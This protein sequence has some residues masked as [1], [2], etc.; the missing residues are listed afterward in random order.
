LH[1]LSSFQRTGS[2]GGTS[3]PSNRVFAVIRRT[4]PEYRTTVSL[5]T[6]FFGVA[7]AYIRRKS[8]P[9][10]AAVLHRIAAVL[11]ASPLG[12]GPRRLA[13]LG[14]RPPG[15]L[16][17]PAARAASSTRHP[18]G[19]AALCGDAGA[20][21]KTSEISGKWLG[22]QPL[23][24]LA[25]ETRVY[26][27]ALPVLGCVVPYCLC[28]LSPTDGR[29]SRPASKSGLSEY[30]RALS[31]S[32]QK[33][34]LGDQ[35]SG[36]GN[37][38]PGNHPRRQGRLSGGSCRNRAMPECRNAAKRMQECPRASPACCCSCL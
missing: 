30:A 15:A 23:R 7:G 31:V 36:V 29:I 34:H 5:S 35:A 37:R 26:D 3:T 18:G 1:V 6:P 28:R 22:C 33:D 2:L 10:F 4:H 20:P 17:K 14:C 32:T 11:A 12:L 21:G 13:G 8:R 38:E 19:E 16:E 27:I 24:S 9:R 25:R